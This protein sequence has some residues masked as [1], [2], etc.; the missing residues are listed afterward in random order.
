MPNFMNISRINVVPIPDA[1][2]TQGVLTLKLFEAMAC[3]V[4]TVIGDLPGVREHVK[5]RT[6]ACLARSESRES[7]SSAINSMIS[8][9]GLYRR[10]RQNDLKAAPY[11][12]WREIAKDMADAMTEATLSCQKT[13][14]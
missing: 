13:P 2:C 7:L 6:T 4:P 14:C 1:P 3:G 8:D 9:K 10:I 12:D 5:D 11:Y